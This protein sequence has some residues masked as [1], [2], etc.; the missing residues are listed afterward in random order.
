MIHV[1]SIR[2]PV[3]ALLLLGLCRS[4]AIAGP[5]RQKPGAPSSSRARPRLGT[6]VGTQ[7]YT[8]DP[9]PAT[10]YPSTSTQVHIEARPA[11][12]RLYLRMVRGGGRQSEWRQSFRIVSDV[13]AAD[14]TRVIEVAQPSVSS[15]SARHN[16]RR[17]RDW[18]AAETAPDPA[19]AMLRQMKG[20]GTFEIRGDQVTWR[21]RG[22]GMLAV[23]GGASSRLTWDETFKG[24]RP[25]RRARMSRPRVTRRSTPEATMREAW[26][27]ALAAFRADGGILW[28]NG[29]GPVEGVH[30]TSG[31][32]FEMS[33][34]L[35]DG[36]RIRRT[37][38]DGEVVETS[39]APD[40]AVTEKRERRPAPAPFIFLR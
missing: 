12:G 21:N 30:P 8:A 18:V 27:R 34:N 13:T 37:A 39:I 4:P 25:P 33:G 22:R 24:A 6:F 20:G 31:A 40:G 9:E 35:R 36:I 17:L 16:E 29:I 14:G 11:L 32:R 7:R 19:T 23:D 10:S 3:V 26:D 15:R 28:A 38:A 1:A 5:P 2:T